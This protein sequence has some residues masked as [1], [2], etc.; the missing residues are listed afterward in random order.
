[1]RVTYSS[2]DSQPGAPPPP[3]APPRFRYAM[4]RRCCAGSAPLRSDAYRG[5]ASGHACARAAPGVGLGSTVHAR[6]RP[7]AC[8]RQ[9]GWHG[10]APPVAQTPCTAP[11]GGGSRGAPRSASTPAWPARN[12]GGRRAARGPAHVEEARQQQRRK[13]GMR[14]GHSR[15]HHREREGKLVAQRHLSRARRARLSGPRPHAQQRARPH[16][17]PQ[18]A[19]PCDRPRAAREP[20][21]ERSAIGALQRLSVAHSAGLHAGAP[22]L[23]L[24]LADQR[25]GQLQAGIR[26]PLARQPAQELRQ[27]RRLGSHLRARA[28]AGDGGVPGGV[29]RALAACA[30]A[31]RTQARCAGAAGGRGGGAAAAPAAAFRRSAARSA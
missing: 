21:A 22:R 4:A 29:W 12:T 25:G 24:G 15:R 1:M 13:V 19:P 31:T 14:G 26:A 30:P 7:G 5:T 2:V 11:H 16:P 17:A 9:R 27:R 10:T 8:A 6:P 3:A 18:R 20:P 23:R 28:R